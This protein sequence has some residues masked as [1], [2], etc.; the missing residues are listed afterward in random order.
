MVGNGII[1][2]PNKILINTNIDTTTNTNTIAL[3]HGS[4]GLS[5]PKP[6]QQSQKIAPHTANVHN[7]DN[8][9]IIYLFNF[10]LVNI[11]TNPVAGM[12]LAT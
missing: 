1:N 11:P 3:F 2:A 5:F 4:G 10:N 8:I 7:N 6:H 12:L 9:A